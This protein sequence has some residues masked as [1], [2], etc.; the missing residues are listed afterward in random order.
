MILGLIL[1]ATAEIENLVRMHELAARI[2]YVQH[3]RGKVRL[4]ATPVETARLLGVDEA[5]LAGHTIEVDANGYRVSG[6]GAAIV[7]GRYEG[8]LPNDES[9]M[10]AQ[11]KLARYS[12]R[13]NAHADAARFT[14]EAM[15]RMQQEIIEKRGTSGGD[16]GWGTPFMVEVDLDGSRYR[17][18]SAGADRVFDPTSWNRPIDN[19]PSS[20][21]VIEN[22]Q[23]RRRFNV[24]RYL[25]QR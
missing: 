20:D 18:I 22:G 23:F 24:D 13:M 9:L 1:F 6:N 4:G 2:Q 19:D 7:N 12:D 21:M 16:D 10:A 17:I 14:I 8:T 3:T 15:L 25:L 11:A 5:L